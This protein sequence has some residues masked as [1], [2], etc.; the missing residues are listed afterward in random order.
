MM[1]LTSCFPFC[2]RLLGV[3]QVLSTR[4]LERV[5]WARRCSGHCRSSNHSLDVT[6]NARCRVTNDKSIRRSQK[7]FSTLYLR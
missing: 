1:V 5:L 4:L 2:H 3:G 6:S 7:T